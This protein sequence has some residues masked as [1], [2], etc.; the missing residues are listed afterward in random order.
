MYEASTTLATS[1]ATAS[2][3]FLEAI[4]LRVADV[5][6]ERHLIGVSRSAKDDG[7]VGSTKSDRFRAVQIGPQ[8]VARLRDHVARRMEHSDEDPRR[9]LLFVMPIRRAKQEKGRW[10]SKPELG[11]IDR[12]TV[13]RSWHKEALRDAGLRDMPLHAL[14]HTAAAAWLSTGQPLMFVQR[15]LGHAQI[16]TTERLYGHLEEVFV[17]QAAAETERAIERA[18]G[19]YATG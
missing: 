11:S 16:T 18:G 2:R 13:S 8:L 6:L 7:S 9:A 12:N 14:R 1:A 3:Y 15:Q 19:L 4:A 5:D 17:R 10:A